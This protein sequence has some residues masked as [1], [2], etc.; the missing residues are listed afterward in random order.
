MF[1][2]GVSYLRGMSLLVLW[3]VLAAFP[4]THSSGMEVVIPFLLQESNSKPTLPS[5]D[6]RKK[7]G[8]CY[9]IFKLPKIR[10]T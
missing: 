3:V 4:I 1:W 8:V 9:F 7:R 5:K 10:A 2:E 6:N